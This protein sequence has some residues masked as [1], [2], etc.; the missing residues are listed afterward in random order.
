MN[1]K[2]K[3]IAAVLLGNFFFGTSV[4][5]VKHITPVFLPPMALT[6]VRIIVSALLFWSM[7][8]FNPVKMGF[9]KKD[10]LRL[11]LCALAGIALN[12]S[13]SIRGMS[14]TSPIHASLLILT[15]PIVITFLATWFLKER[16]NPFKIVGLF[17][18]ISGGVLLIFS[19]DLSMVAG[20]HQSLGDVFIIMGAIS[21]AT[22]VVSLKPLALKYKANHILQW[23]FLFGLIIVLPIGWHDLASVQWIKFDLLSWICL[24]Y[25]I[26]GAT[27]FAY[28][29]MNYSIRV[30]GASVTGSFSYTQPFFGAIASMLLLNEN[31]SLPKI[32]AAILIMGGVFLT[33]YKS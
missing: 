20:A 15:T 24:G 13:F 32:A 26:L 19:R 25:V 31:L 12:Q 27:F 17:L 30:L 1:Q 3:A 29:L 8:A 11:V 16:L 21:Y 33:N 2:N 22:Y 7:Y 28:Q 18:G 10:F 5:A 4:I 23:L 9:E 14:L 6:M